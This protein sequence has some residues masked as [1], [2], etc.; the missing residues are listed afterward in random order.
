MFKLLRFFS[1]TSF[2]AILVTAGLLTLLFREVT[3]RETVR[4]ARLT[5]LA[6]ARTALVSVR[7]QL[8][9][10]LP[11]AAR[12]G[13]ED[14]AV[15]TLSSRL[16]EVL[17]EMA[18]DALA[19]KVN[20]YDPRGTVVFSTERREIGRNESGN[21]ELAS[22]ATGAVVTRLNY[23]DVF[24]RF[25][26]DA[27]EANLMKTYLPVRAASGDI[28]AVFSLSTDVS[29]LA[30]QN[31]RTVSLILAVVALVLW[32]LYAVLVVVV[33]RSRTLIEAQQ[34]TIRER[35]AA[36]EMLSALMLSSDEMEM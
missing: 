4:L 17:Q 30:A 16:S 15:K 1:L 34:H 3:V 2:L 18:R 7:P 11:A 35:T 8:D 20:I 26:T 27:A 13:P 5:T 36:L 23:R 19:V 32:L 21:A 22:A 24:N 6:L 10:Y 9:D 31:E 29:P 12:T 33:R 14:A 25:A 28:H